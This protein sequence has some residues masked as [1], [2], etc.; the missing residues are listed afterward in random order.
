MVKMN[1]TNNQTSFEYALYMIASSYFDKATC[2]SGV[3]ERKMLI[4]YKELKLDKQYQMEE[5]CISFMDELV[6]K[7]P[8]H[9]FNRNVT[10][11]LNRIHSGLTEIIF[12]DKHIVFALQAKYAGKKPTIKY[13]T[14]S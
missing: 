9:F 8:K 7:M 5:I 6:A 10:V 1:F 14:W 13:R 2:K 12:I 4:Q 11:K 3:L